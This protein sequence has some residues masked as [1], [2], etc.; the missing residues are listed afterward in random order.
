MEDR[1][2]QDLAL[3]RKYHRDHHALLEEV[4]S[5]AVNETIASQAADPIDGVISALRRIRQERQ[6][7]LPPRQPHDGS[8]SVVPPKAEPEQVLAGAAT[9]RLPDGGAPPQIELLLE[10]ATAAKA[11]LGPL[12]LQEP[13]GRQLHATSARIYVNLRNRLLC[14]WW[15][16]PTVKLTLPAVRLA[17]LR[18]ESASSPSSAYRSIR[19]WRASLRLISFPR[20]AALLAEEP[21]S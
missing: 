18:L 14:A 1:K 6:E 12:L 11:A 17:S 19:L 20:P 21:S 8:A 13:G 3:P 9:P 7:L 4:L 2:Q 15:A 10:Q 5:R 16:D